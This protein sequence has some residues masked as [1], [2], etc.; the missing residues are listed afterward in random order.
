MKTIP[1]PIYPISIYITQSLTTKI[2]G[3]E[4]FEQHEYD[5]PDEHG[6]HEHGEQHG[7]HEHR[8]HEQ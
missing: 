6:E 8:D 7:K 1:R 3:N 2:L 5:E 4:Q